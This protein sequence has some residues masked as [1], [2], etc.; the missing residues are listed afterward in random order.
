MRCRST[1][2][3]YQLEAESAVFGATG[4]KGFLFTV[5]DTGTGMSAETLSCIYKAFFTTKGI[6]YTGLGLWISCEIIERHRGTIEVRSSQRP[7]ASGTVFQLFL[8][9][10]G[11]AS[12]ERGRRPFTLP[13]ITLIRLALRVGTLGREPGFVGRQAAAPK[14]LPGLAIASAKR[15]QP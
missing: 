7:G 6:S 10:E 11:I 3:N 1:G 12:K 5:A 2:D 8:P 15:L 14:D 9:S 13:S 4:E